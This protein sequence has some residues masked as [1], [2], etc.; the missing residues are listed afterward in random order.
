MSLAG[1]LGT[2]I[3]PEETEN[4]E[5]AGTPKP[6]RRQSSL[7]ASTDREAV[8]GQRYRSRDLPVATMLT[9]SHSCAAHGNIL[10]DPRES[11]RLQA[12][13]HQERRHILDSNFPASSPTTHSQ[14]NPEANQSKPTSGVAFT[15]RL[16]HFTVQ[17]QKPSCQ[18][19]SY[20]SRCRH[21]GL[22]YSMHLNISL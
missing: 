21:S 5:D 8:R 4:F 9:V 6:A 22:A 16:N 20:A 7:T 1:P 2:S 19:I 14:R 12:A 18:Y 11:T 3:N 15:Y 10:E 17:V 13:T